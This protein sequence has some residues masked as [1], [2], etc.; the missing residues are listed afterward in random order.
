MVKSFQTK[1]IFILAFTWLA[2]TPL[3]V[4]AAAKPALPAKPRN[5]IVLIADGC[6]SE[7]YTLARWF[8]GAPLSVDALLVGGVKTFIA[9][10]VI[11]DSAPTATAYAT[12]YRTSDKL[13][14][15]GPKA[16]TI[17]VVSE[18]PAEMQYQTAGHGSGRGETQ[19]DG[20]GD[21]LPPRGSPMRRPAAYISHVPSRSQEDLIMEQA[22]YQGIDVVMGGGGQYLLPKAASGKRTDG[23]DLKAVLLKKGYTLAADRNDMAAF[24]IGKI[25]RHVRRQ[26]HGA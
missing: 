12:G 25:F 4:M 6:G 17:P 13:I 20:D 19:G 16:G 9:D 18:P 8:K 7:H 10:S 11:A 15:V 22:V 21:R 23:E 3:A 26:S 1:M 5:V 14:G 24:V 2:L